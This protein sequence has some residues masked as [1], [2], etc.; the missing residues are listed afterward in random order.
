MQASI[1][2]TAETE[3][4]REQIRR[5]APKLLAR[6]KNVEVFANNSAVSITPE[7]GSDLARVLRGIVG[8]LAR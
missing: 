1:S 6:N 2:I 3:A 8:G 7:D 5:L 4:E